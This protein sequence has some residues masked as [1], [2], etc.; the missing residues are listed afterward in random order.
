MPKT[1]HRMSYDDNS[2]HTGRSWKMAPVDQYQGIKPT[3]SYNDPLATPTRMVAARST[4][5]TA[6]APVLDWNPGQFPQSGKPAFR[7]PGSGR[8][9]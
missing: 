3:V 8:H 2:H 6:G 9:K 4:Q 7:G 5:R 1:P